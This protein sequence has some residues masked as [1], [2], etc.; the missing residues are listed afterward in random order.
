MFCFVF[1]QHIILQNHY[2]QVLQVGD[3]SYN[4]SIGYI[5]LSNSGSTGY[6]AISTRQYCEEYCRYSP[7]LRVRKVLLHT[8]ACR[9]KPTIM[10]R[11][12]LFSWFLYE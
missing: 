1:M 6:T 10:N 2:V 11:Q 9:E 4:N 5:A 8:N 7:V 12:V 3:N